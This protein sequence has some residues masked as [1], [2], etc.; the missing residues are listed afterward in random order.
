MKGLRFLAPFILVQAAQAMDRAPARLAWW[1][2][3]A[4]RGPLPPAQRLAHIGAYINQ[5]DDDRED[6]VHA[7]ITDELMAVEAILMAL[8]I[9][10]AMRARLVRMYVVD[11]AILQDGVRY[12]RLPVGPGSKFVFPRPGPFCLP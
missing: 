10:P 12:G 1:Q 7:A 2:E 4:S 5:L 3:R 6:R 11:A 8:T 9:D